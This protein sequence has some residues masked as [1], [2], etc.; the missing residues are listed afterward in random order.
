MLKPPSACSLPRARSR[1]LLLL[2][3]FCCQGI[4]L[5]GTSSQVR[6]VFPEQPGPLAGSQY[7]RHI[8]PLSSPKRPTNSLLLG[9][10]SGSGCRRRRASRSLRQPRRPCPIPTTAL[11]LDTLLG[12]QYHA[13]GVWLSFR[14]NSRGDDHGV[15]QREEG[16]RQGRQNLRLLAARRGQARGRQGQAEGGEFWGRTPVL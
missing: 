2:F 6:P 5:S 13:S 16:P 14:H 9:R 7:P 15:R 12:C 1:F 3:I 8:G 10:L 11:V 4:V